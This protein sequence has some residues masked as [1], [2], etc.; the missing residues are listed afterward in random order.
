MGLQSALTT[1]LTGLQ[2][3]ETTIDVVGNNVANSSTVG[4][5]ESEAVFATQFLQTISIGGAPTAGSGGTNP[6]QIG[7]GVKVA[8]VTPDFS[9]GTIEISSNP[10]DIAIQ[11]DGFLMVQSSNGVLYTRNGQLQLNANNEIVTT[12][13]QR[14]LG[15]SV[16]DNY[17]LIESTPQPLTIP[18]GQ[19]RVAQATENAYMTGVLNPAV[20]VATQPE[21]IQSLVLGDGAIEQP[22]AS[23]MVTTDFSETDAPNTGSASTGGAVGGPNAGTVQYRMVYLDAN[24]NESSVG[25]TITLSGHTGGS[26]DLSSLP[27]V[28]NGIWQ[29]LAIYR[30]EADGSTFYALDMSGYTAGDATFTDTQNDAAIVANPELNN[31]SL[32]PD[33]Y[34]YYVTYYDSTPGQE[35]E[36]TPSVKLGP[37]S[38]TDATGGRLHIDLSG[39]DAPT[40]S[41]FDT[42][43]IYRSDD[44]GSTYKRVGEVAAPT[45]AVHTTT[46]VDSMSNADWTTSTDELDLTGPTV[47]GATLLTD[48]ITRSG[49]VVSNPFQIGT[50]SF[51]PEKDGVTISSKSME[52]TAT[53]TVSDLMSF[54]SDTMGLASTSSDNTTPFD[55]PQAGVT[56]ENGRLTV[57][58]NY[59]EENAVSV[60]LTAFK[61]VPTGSNTS[62]SVTL[63]FGTTQVADGPGTST[64]FVVYDS[65]GL[66]LNVRVT[67]VLEDKAGNS[68]TYRWYAT[69]SS[70]EPTNGQSTVIGD[71]LLVFDSKGDLDE[72]T[73]ARISIFRTDTAS[74]S[75]LEIALD[76]SSVKSLGEV[77][78]LGENISTL[79]VSSQDGFP[80]GVLTDF[81][82]SEDG[83]IQGQFSNGTQRTIGQLLMAR[84]TNNAGLQQVGDSLFQIGVNSGEPV[85]GRPGEDGIGTLTAGAVELSNT[86][87]GQNLIELILASTQYRG[88]AR[89]ISAS[90]ELLDELLALRR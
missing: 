64:E 72:N 66:P 2:A 89:V 27:T 82:I 50:L 46:F 55:N 23:G 44:T 30:T 16:D 33:T 17:N 36:S 69:S 32:E 37:V 52:I 29:D 45:T 87:I 20:E 59:G 1:A 78:A 42:L 71:G 7:L 31:S 49:D 3:A 61:V 34:T 57:T 74:E 24:G 5:K 65:L 4:F 28:P 73:D 47:D 19:E 13:G 80:P 51:A 68:T 6:R 35:L 88:G 83:L 22:D 76:F 18:L 40:D 70:N 63:N 58:S 85:V 53:S 41:R 62:E 54:M 43:R 26:V 56:L 14:V 67:T 39:L 12:T 75:P 21:I 84:F 86:D 15:Y 11:G 90:Q 48:V 10:L 8:A 77:D 81:V 25:S 60:P 38:V 9:Q 79:N